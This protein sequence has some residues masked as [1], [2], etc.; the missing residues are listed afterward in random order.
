MYGI[1]DTLASISSAVAL[2]MHSLDNREDKEASH[3]DFHSGAYFHVTH[4]LFWKKCVVKGLEV[5]LGRL[6]RMNDHRGVFR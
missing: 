6:E 2:V 3:H 4:R 5:S 1:L